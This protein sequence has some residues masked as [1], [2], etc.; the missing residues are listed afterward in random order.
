MRASKWDRAWALGRRASRETWGALLPALVGTLL[1]FLLPKDTRSQA[2]QADRVPARAKGEA[3]ELC[4]AWHRGSGE[5]VPLDLS[6]V[7]RAYQALKD[8]LAQTLDTPRPEVAK[9]EKKPYDAG[10]PACREDGVRTVPLPRELGIRFRGRLLYFVSVGALGHLALPPEVE[11][12]PGAQILVVRAGSL[13]DLPE[14][15][16]ELGRPVGLGT[17]EFAK[18]LGVRCAN[19]W[20]RISEKG[21]ALELHESR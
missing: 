12:D 5:T 1:F 19:T 9:L 6:R 21:D 7:K 20:L 11:K 3:A 2:A 18:S 14:I 16:K 13:G 4:G 15:A 10:L 17:R 8:R